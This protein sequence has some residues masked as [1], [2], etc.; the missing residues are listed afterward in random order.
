MEWYYVKG[1]N[2]NNLN[3]KMIDFNNRNKRI[4]LKIENKI[5][6]YLN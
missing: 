6:V 1:S 4:V 2:L 3:I 5:L